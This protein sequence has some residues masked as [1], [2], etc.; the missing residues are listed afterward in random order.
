VIIPFSL[1]SEG[2]YQDQ[3]THM[4]ITML[5]GNH[6]HYGEETIVL[7]NVP[8]EEC[9]TT[10]VCLQE[11]CHWPPCRLPQEHHPWSFPN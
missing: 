11:Y 7:A 1:H 8:K 3:N 6:I 10:K 5:V 9:A 2:R 4:Q